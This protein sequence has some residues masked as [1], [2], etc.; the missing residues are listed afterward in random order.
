LQTRVFSIRLA[1]SL[2]GESTVLGNVQ[3]KAQM[4]FDLTTER[5]VNVVTKVE[6]YEV[7]GDSLETPEQ[8][9]GIAERLDNISRQE[10]VFAAMSWS[11]L[12]SG[13]AKNWKSSSST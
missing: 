2:A 6:N 1:E 9:K 8:V 4:E 5:L 10:L 12:K 3:K 13:I 11:Q 7:A